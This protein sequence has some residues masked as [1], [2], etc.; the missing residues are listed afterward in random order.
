MKNYINYLLSIFLGFTIGFLYQ[1]VS[2]NVKIIK[3]GNRHELEKMENK[4][5]KDNEKCFR[6]LKEETE[7]VN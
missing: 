4:I 2:P 7:C 6:I 5:F 1:Y 3:E